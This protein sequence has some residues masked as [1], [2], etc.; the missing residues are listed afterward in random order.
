[1]DLAGQLVE[2]MRTGAGP[3]EFFDVAQEIAELNDPRVIPMLIG[4]IEAD[5]TYNTV[6]GV[7]YFGLSKLTGV[8]YE[9][10]HDGAWWRQWWEKNRA[11]YPKDIAAL[12]IPKIEAG[13]AAAGAGGAGGPMEAGGDADKKYFLIP[14]AARQQ[15]PPPHGY[16]LLLVLPGGDGSADFHDFVRSIHRQALPEDFIVAQLI[17]PRWSAEQFEKVVW[18]TRTNAFEGMKFSTEQFI[19]AV[20]DDVASKHM[21]DTRH[22][23]ALAWSS[24]G[25]AVYAAS[26]AEGSRLRGALVA[27]SVYWPQNLPDRA[28]AR[29]KAFYLLH[30]PE[31]FIPMSHPETALQEL[32]AAGATAKLATYKGGHGWHGDVFDNIREGI[33]WLQKQ[34]SSEA[35]T[36][37]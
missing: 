20:I 32:T 13:A 4:I 16:K 29:G 7:G 6:Y 5:G 3:G 27:M 2:L 12:E 33:D 26:L 10:S 19:D 35:S 34:Q 30:S 36:S 17:A 24:G 18:P 22:I 23:Y 37:P 11:R 9:E 8:R 1:L 21:V 25:P 14:P 28:G 15:V 31:D